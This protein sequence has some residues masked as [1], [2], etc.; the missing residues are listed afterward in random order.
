MENIFEI[1]LMIVEDTYLIL[2]SS[3]Q[4][5]FICQA[6]GSDSIDLVLSK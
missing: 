1:F 2:T 4:L 6:I 5:Y 3:Q